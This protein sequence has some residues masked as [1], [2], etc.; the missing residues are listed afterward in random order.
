MLHQEI[1]IC[2]IHEKSYRFPEIIIRWVGFATIVIKLDTFQEIVQNLQSTVLIVVDLA[3]FRSIAVLVLR[4]CSHIRTYMQIQEVST[5]LTMQCNIEL[6]SPNL[7][8][9]SRKKNVNNFEH[10]ANHLGS[11]VR[12]E[13]IND[14]SMSWIRFDNFFKPFLTYTIHERNLIT[15]QREPT[16]RKSKSDFFN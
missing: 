12:I 15:I 2:Q 3:T 8:C 13:L 14:H 10:Y 1:W 7:R 5:V 11:T 16:C 6:W 9:I 4:N